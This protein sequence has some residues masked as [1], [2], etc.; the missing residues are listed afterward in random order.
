MKRF[1]WPIVI[2][3]SSILFMFSSG[4]NIQSPLRGALTFWFMLVCPGMAF[5]R[6]LNLKEPI[7]EWVLAV[8]LSMALGTLFAEAAVVNQWWSPTATGMILAVLSLFGA[9]LQVILKFRIQ[10]QKQVTQ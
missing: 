10:K 4:A 6:L 2:G 3:M 8:A 7:F 5:I 1:I 9:G